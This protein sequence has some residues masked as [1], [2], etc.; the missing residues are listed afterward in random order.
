MSHEVLSQ[1]GIILF[2]VELLVEMGDT[3]VI[4]STDG[5][6]DGQTLPTL[7]SPCLDKAMQSIMMLKY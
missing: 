5:R 1:A 6:K 4:A 3:G 2:P 7:S